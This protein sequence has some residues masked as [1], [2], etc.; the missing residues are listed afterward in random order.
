[1]IK[2][3]KDFLNTIKDHNQT[4][5]TSATYEFDK[6]THEDIEY[7]KHNKDNPNFHELFQYHFESRNINNE[8][9][10]NILIQCEKEFEQNYQ[11]LL[12][13]KLDI[14]NFD[15]NELY[16]KFIEENNI[17]SFSRTIFHRN[18]TKLINTELLKFLSEQSV[19]YEQITLDLIDKLTRTNFDDYRNITPKLKLVFA[20]NQNVFNNNIFKIKELN[21]Y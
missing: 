21:K 16:I 11:K 14:Y 3:L 2:L 6:L 18:I 4:N 17:E 19:K 15:I 13:T 1:M 20:D 12:N 9:V 10:R 5:D 8:D 7:I